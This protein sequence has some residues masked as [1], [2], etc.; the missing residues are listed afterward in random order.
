MGARGGGVCKY[1]Y[2]ISIG[3]GKAFAKT[4]IKTVY[5][6]VLF[7]KIHSMCSELKQYESL[8]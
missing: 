3:F 5:E 8:T 1:P 7:L 6:I 4:K 2:P